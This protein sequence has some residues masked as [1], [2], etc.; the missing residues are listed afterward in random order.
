MNTVLYMYIS[1]YFVGLAFM[2]SALSLVLPDI[3]KDVHKILTN[4]EYKV[5]NFGWADIGKL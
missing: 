3:S 2:S 4:L 1:N 5:G